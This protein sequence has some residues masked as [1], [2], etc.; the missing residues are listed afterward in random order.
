MPFLRYR[1]AQEQRDS[2]RRRTIRPS[3]PR[4]IRDSRRAR[5]TRT[6]YPVVARPSRSVGRMDSI[7]KSRRSL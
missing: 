5:G 7:V 6:I 1:T 2:M 3:H 4:L